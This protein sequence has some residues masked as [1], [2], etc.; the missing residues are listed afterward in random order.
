MYRSAAG[1]SGWSVMQTLA[2]SEG[3]ESYKL[4]RARDR[5]HNDMTISGRRVGV[6]SVDELSEC[7]TYVQSGGAGVG[8]LVIHRGVVSVPID[9]VCDRAIAFTKATIDKMPP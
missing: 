8:T 1:N 9:E 2:N 7:E 5:W 3:L 6:A 4:K